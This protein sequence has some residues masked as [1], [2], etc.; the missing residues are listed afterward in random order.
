MTSE[1]RCRAPGGPRAQS[2]PLERGDLCPHLLKRKSTSCV[3]AHVFP[4]K[5]GIT[6]L[7][8]LLY[9]SLNRIIDLHRIPDLRQ[10]MASLELNLFLCKEGTAWLVMITGDD[11]SRALTVMVAD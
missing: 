1:R 6:G 11:L 2:F 3:Y 4:L 8:R 7:P 9:S 10:V 5:F